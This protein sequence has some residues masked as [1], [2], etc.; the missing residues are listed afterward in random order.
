MTKRSKVT[1]VSLIEK[2]GKVGVKDREEMA[3]KV[4]AMATEKGV[5]HNVRGHMITEKK[6]AQLISA[7]IRDITNQ[8]TGKWSLLEVKEDADKL[9]ILPIEKVGAKA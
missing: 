8:R 6:V 3:K 1:L 7:F 5:T 2:F 9:F 4:L